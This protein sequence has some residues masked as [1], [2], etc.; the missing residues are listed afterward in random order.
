MTEFASKSRIGVGGRN[1][2]NV[3]MTDKIPETLLDELLRLDADSERDAYLDQVCGGDGELRR[4]LEVLVERHQQAEQFFQ[5]VGLD[6]EP[7][8]S[9]DEDVTLQDAMSS[10][11]VGAVIGRYKILEKIGEGGMGDVYMAQQSEPVSRKVAFKIIKFGLDTKQ[12]IARF[13]A[14]RQA[15]A[16]MDH[17]NIAKV[18]DGGATETGRPYFV[19]ELVQG[20]PITEFCD[21]HQLS[22]H[23]RLQ[24]FMKVCEAIQSAHHKGGIHRDI[25]P[26]NILV[27]FRNDIPDP[28]VIDFG[29][30]KA[31]HQKLTEKTLFTNYGQM[32]GTP[33][34]MSPEQAEMTSLD[35]DTRT[36]VY[37]LGVLLYELLTG[38]PPFSSKDLLS[39]GYLEMKRII[40]EEEPVRP[41]TRF[42]T[43][44]AK[45]RTEVER[46]RG[47][48]TSE[49]AKH[50][51]GDLDWIALK[52]LEKD[53]RKRYGTPSELM[54]DIERHLKGEAVSAVAPSIP[55]LF[56]KFYR[57]HRVLVRSALI[58]SLILVLATVVSATF[59]V[60]NS[61]LRRKAE[62]SEQ[63]M[64]EQSLQLENNL[65]VSDMLTVETAVAKEEFRRAEQLLLQH[66]IEPSGRDLRDLA[67]RFYWQRAR[68]DWLYAIPAHVGSTNRNAEVQGLASA[69]IIRRIHILNKS[70]RLLTMGERDTVRLWDL[71][72]R[73]MIH[74]WPLGE[75]FAV[76]PN[77]QYL[78]F[79][80]P[81]RRLV[82]W[83]LE[84]NQLIRRADGGEWSPSRIKFTHDSRHLVVKCSDFRSPVEKGRVWVEEVRSGEVVFVPDGYW[85]DF[86]V[87]PTEPVIL[88]TGLIHDLDGPSGT[89]PPFG[90]S[91]GYLWNIDRKE[92]VGSPIAAR[93]IMG[94]GVRFSPKGTYL[95]MSHSDDPSNTNSDVDTHVFRV[96]TGEKVS[97]LKEGDL[98]AANPFVSEPTVTFSRDEKFIATPPTIYSPKVKVWETETGELRAL[99]SDFSSSVTAMAFHPASDDI[100]IATS[101]DQTMIYWDWKNDQVLTRWTG[102]RSQISALGV[103]KD[104]KHVVTGGR[105]GRLVFWPPQLRN[106]S[107]QLPKWI[108]GN[109][110]PVFSQ[111]G[112][113]LVLGESAKT[114]PSTEPMQDIPV[115]RRLVSRLPKIKHAVFS[116]ET[117]GRLWDVPRSEK[118]LGFSVDERYLLSLSTNQVFSRE[119]S[120]GTLFSSVDL[121]EPITLINFDRPFPRFQVLSLDGSVFAAFNPDRTVRIVSVATG[122]TINTLP[123][124]CSAGSLGFSP[125][126]N[127]VVF[128]GDK[129]ATAGVWDPWK[130]EVVLLE[131]GENGSASSL[132]VSPDERFV[133]GHNR[134][135]VVQIWSLGTGKLIQSLAVD[136]P[137]G[138]FFTPDSR[139]LANLHVLGNSKS[140]F[141]HNAL[142][143]F[144]L[145]TGRQIADLQSGPDSSWVS[146]ILSPNGQDLIFRKHYGEGNT[147]LMHIPSIEEIDASIADRFSR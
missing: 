3:R 119:I 130:D 8:L 140:R 71:A 111:S 113:Y 53:R 143:L 4:R 135:H 7:E 57:R 42:G 28:K 131:L 49:I 30:A 129:R 93:G 138:L 29:I 136:E 37:S 80:D 67:W 65:Y 103:G 39:A 137:G 22:T 2:E 40:I 78:C 76:S 73:S 35:I 105:D 43:M 133:A 83:D 108:G 34:Y 11:E 16:M 51:R 9:N 32:I 64:Q 13:E 94:M 134:N 124:K 88:T 106:P 142:K 96:A 56:Q 87:S 21:R 125:T 109:S 58:V 100:L 107:N 115:N 116:T 144:E 31:T 91:R 118:V 50:C 48:E 81:K 18:L 92:M 114:N 123:H 6:S 97:V 47:M 84:A 20:L 132:V 52:C 12:T 45:S 79:V 85:F 121:D 60:W 5:G 145:R 127:K 41:S 36:D 23:E 104:G 59:A 25:K 77:E 17:P 146:A 10:V 24:L 128:V 66:R 101:E 38:L 147:Q 70:Q 19:M 141:I 95:A 33:T 55:Y 1:E 15:L 44:D 112:R 61:Q 99:Y 120:S 82:V 139:L 98:G 102:H 63:K 72:S 74:E 117:R 126:S 89:K 54:S 122:E 86:A 46:S 68:G 69:S 27:Q 110:S 75:R 14:E 26:S 90:A 62:A